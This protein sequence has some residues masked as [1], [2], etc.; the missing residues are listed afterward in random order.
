[1]PCPPTGLWTCAA[2]P[3]Q[4]AAPVAETLGAAV[5]DAVG[6]EPAAPLE[7]ELG[8][9]LL[10]QRGHHVL[11]REVVPPPQRRRQDADDPPVIGPAHREE[12]VK[13]VAP[14]I[15]VELVR[16]HGPGRLGIGDE[17]HVLVGRARKPDA[18]QLA[19]RAVRAVAAGDL[20]GREL[21]GRAVR[22]LERGRDVAGLLLEGDELGVPLHGDAPARAGARPSS[23]RCRPGPASGRRGT[24]SGPRRCRPAGCAPAAA[25][26]PTCWRRC[27][28]CRARARARRSR[29][30]SRSR[31]CAPARPIARVCSA[32][33][34]C[35]SMISARTPRRPSWLASISPV[36]PAPTTRTSVSIHV[37]P[38]VKPAWSSR[39]R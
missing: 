1:M 7:G 39:R 34:E 10:A 6:R 19:H 28:A 25:L 24:D 36:G 31:A 20:R 32:G 26:P 5:M 12:Q 30:S 17:E 23:V 8:A 16:H 3:E 18:V 37:P 11:E 22:L 13:P 35:R 9:R 15:D 27:R 33:P 2:S 4:E 29:A 21:P 14:E 38:R